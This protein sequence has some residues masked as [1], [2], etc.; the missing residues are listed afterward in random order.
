MDRIKLLICTKQ[1]EYGE[2]L[3]RFLSA[4]RNPDIEAELLTADA[5]EAVDAIMEK[6]G[7]EQN[8]CVIS[9]DREVLEH[10]GGQ[11]V[12]LVSLPETEGKRE[13]FMYQRVEDIYRQILSLAGI[14]VRKE[15]RDLEL[16]L[17]KVTCVYAPGESEEKTVFALRTAIDRAERGTVLY[18]NLCGYPLL[19]REEQEGISNLMLCNKLEVFEERLRELAFRAGQISV[20]APARHFRDLFDFSQEEVRRFI[21]YMKQQTL[22]EAVVIELGQLFDFTFVL[23]AE[24]D[25]VLMPQEPGILAEKKRQLFCGYCYREGQETVWER[26]KFVPVAANCP[27]SWEEILRIVGAD[28]E[29]ENR[30]GGKKPKRENKRVGFG[31]GTGR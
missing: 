12:A 29:E 7:T 14:P 6:T 18:I 23:L 17:P 5:G 15:A 2:K 24:A 10:V 19:F 20:L 27:E 31:S 16:S 1:K 21:A 22:Y 9:D 11:S 26:I 4:Q 8:V 30:D 25:A 28:G 13:I 3:L